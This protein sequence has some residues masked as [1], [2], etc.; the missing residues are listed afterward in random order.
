MRGRLSQLR[1]ALDQ[2][3]VDGG[4]VISL[5]LAKLSFIDAAALSELLHYQLLALSRNQE[6][7]VESASDEVVAVFE[8]FDL[9]PILMRPR[10]PPRP[11]DHSLLARR[12]SVRHRPLIG[13]GHL[14]CEAGERATGIE[15]V[16]GFA[17][18][19]SRCSQNR[20]SGHRK[21]LLKFGLVE[22]S[23]EQPF[24][25]LSHPGGMG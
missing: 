21:C 9:R 5:D 13:A 19:P 1:A 14:T 8:A 4:P 17:S 24:K 2:A 10:S 15:P 16:L 3:L 7:R 20:F 22:S 23:Y 12:R 18:G 11:D 25:V 6:L